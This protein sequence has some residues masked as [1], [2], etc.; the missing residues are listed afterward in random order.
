MQLAE[1][2]ENLVNLCILL[3]KTKYSFSMDEIKNHFNTSELKFWGIAT[4]D[5]NIN[6]NEFDIFRLIVPNNLPLNVH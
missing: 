6:M 3:V 2:L 5:S 1:I 4:C